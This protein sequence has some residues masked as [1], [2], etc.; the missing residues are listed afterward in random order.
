MAPLRQQRG[1][2][3][4]EREK[5]K[6]VTHLQIGQRINEIYQH[7]VCG[8][9][10]RSLIQHTYMMYEYKGQECKLIFPFETTNYWI[11]RFV[12]Y[13]MDE[14]ADIWGRTERNDAWKHSH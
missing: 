4:R 12:D 8:R 3:Q 10:G 6:T 9:N 5:E 13:L 2:R 1:E 7:C 14:T 11:I